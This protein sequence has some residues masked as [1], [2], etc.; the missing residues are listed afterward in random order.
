MSEKKMRFIKAQTE[1][2]LGDQSNVII[3]TSKDGKAN[4]ALMTREGRGWL[5]QKQMAELF[6]TSV[7]SVSMHMA[8]VLK[9][10]ELDKESTIKYFL[11]VA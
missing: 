5:T 2:A 7:P 10:K 4:V 11:T 1:L 9:D 6:G 8:N 3:Y